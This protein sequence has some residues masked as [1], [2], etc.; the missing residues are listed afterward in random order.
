MAKITADRI[1]E[2]IE[3]V[4]QDPRTY[5]GRAMY[6][7]QCVGV[8]L[9]R[10]RDFAEMLVDIARDEIDVASAMARGVR[11]DDMGRS[12]IYYWPDAGA[13]SDAVVDVAGRGA[14]EEDD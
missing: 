11:T 7:K 13:P 6:G 9:D 10:L 8:T 4:G 2:A 14:D 12:T 3:M 1:W 5:S